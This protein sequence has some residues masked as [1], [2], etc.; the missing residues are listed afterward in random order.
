MKNPWTTL[1]EKEVYNNL[2]ITVEEHQVLNPNG[3]E[4]IY[5]KVHFKNRAIA[6]VPIDDEGNTWLVGQYR[7]TLDEYS[8]EI[9]MGGGP[10]DEG[11]LDSAKR[12][13]K[14]ETGLTAS[15]WQSISRIHTSNSVTD[16]EGFIFLARGLELGETAFDDTEDLAIK[17]VS[18]AVAVG[19]VMSG[20]ITD[21][22]SMAGLLKVHM[23]LNS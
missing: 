7:Y 10:L 15:D 14:E 2:W 16:E 22:L 19:M 9:P 5:G 20:E 17:K 8:W 4:G 11:I 6:I 13:L 1:S 12:E 21:S 3:G 23:I 18:L